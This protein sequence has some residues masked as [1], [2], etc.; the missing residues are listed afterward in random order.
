ML[1]GPADQLACCRVP[2]RRRPI[3][4]AVTTSWQ[5]GMTAQTRARTSCRNGTVK[6]AASGLSQPSRRKCNRLLVFLVQAQRLARWP[7]DWPSITAGPQIACERKSG[8]AGQI[9]GSYTVRAPKSL[10]TPPI[11]AS[12]ARSSNPIRRTNQGTMSP[13]RFT[14]RLAVVVSVRDLQRRSKF[15]FRSSF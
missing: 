3:A 12:H 8:L 7:S 4:G 2:R 13:T 14:L 11:P 15:E 5:S 1:H 9:A 10:A 6:V